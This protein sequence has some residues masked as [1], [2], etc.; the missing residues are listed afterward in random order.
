MHNNNIIKDCIIYDIPKLIKVWNIFS[1]VKKN[2]KTVLAKTEKAS[3]FAKI[4]YSKFNIY[5]LKIGSHILSKMQ[6]K[7]Q[8]MEPYLKFKSY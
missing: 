3:D 5:L 2:K 4:E 8:N 7:M 1:F 6:P